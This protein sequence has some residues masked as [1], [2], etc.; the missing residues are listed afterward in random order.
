[1]PDYSSLSKEIA[2]ATPSGVNSASYSPTNT[3]AQSCPTVGSSWEASDT[4]PPSPNPDLCE[5]MMDS[6]TCTVKDTVSD[7]DVGKL[8]GTVCGL[9]GSVCDGIASNATTG[10]YGAYSMCSAKEKLSFI[11]DV[12]Y[13]QQADQGNGNNACDFDGA[14]STKAAGNTDG[15]CST[16]LKEAASGTG[17]VTA[18]P[19]NGGGSG[20]A[21]TGGSSTSTG[22][23]RPMSAPGSVQV[24]MWQFGVYIVAALIAGVGMIAL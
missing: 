1:M 18:S 5:C 6:L 3:A 22:A 2:S 19:T 11:V 24:G 16:L 20:A 13:R 23:A 21:S 12:Y 14:A 17:T 10:K 9:G 15:S 7:K 8:F 4:L